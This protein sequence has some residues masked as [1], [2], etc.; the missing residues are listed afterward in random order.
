MYDF[1]NTLSVFLLNGE[2]ESDTFTATQPYYFLL[3]ATI[4]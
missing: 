2:D 4:N 1:R 3:S